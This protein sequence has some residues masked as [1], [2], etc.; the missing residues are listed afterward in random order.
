MYLLLA[1]LM[2]VLIVVTPIANGNN[3]QKIGNLGA[4]FYN[5]LFATLTAGIT[6]LLVSLLS[7]NGT[8]LAIQSPLTLTNGLI[9]GALGCAVLF[10]L[11][12]I[13]PKIKAFHI[14]LLPF[15]GQMS[16]GMVLDYYTAGIFDVKRIFGLCLIAAGLLLQHRKDTGCAS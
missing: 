13:A 1:F 16:M 7:G 9:G 8:A 15:L 5:Y 10:L 3:A 2:G 14:V 12:H 11:N 6:Y 4:S